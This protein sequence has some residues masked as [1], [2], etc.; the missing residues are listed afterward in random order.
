MLCNTAVKSNIK[1]AHHLWAACYSYISTL[2]IYL[3]F[4][5]LIHFQPTNLPPH[6]YRHH[7]LP[8]EGGGGGGGLGGS[9]GGLAPADSEVRNLHLITVCQPMIWLC[10]PESLSTPLALCLY[11]WLSAAGSQTDTQTLKT[12][13]HAKAECVDIMQSHETTLIL[14]DKH[15]NHHCSSLFWCVSLC[16]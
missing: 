2:F 16:V 1:S 14:A 11:V 9:Y 7:P 8:L 3:F 12:Q 5:F 10:K 15:T 6:I 4:I 13:L